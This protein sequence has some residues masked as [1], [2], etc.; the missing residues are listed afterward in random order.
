MS[1]VASVLSLVNG[2]PG[3]DV[4]AA[5]RAGLLAAALTPVLAVAWFLLTAR[6]AD[7]ALVRLP[8]ALRVAGVAVAGVVLALVLVAVVFTVVGM[9]TA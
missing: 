4:H 2:T 3:V 8:D 7:G 1:T 5:V 9:P 6:P